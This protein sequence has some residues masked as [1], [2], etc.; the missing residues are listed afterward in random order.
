MFRSVLTKS[1]NWK[2]L[3]KNLELNV[4]ELRVEVGGLGLRRLDSFQIRGGR[5]SGEKE[6]VFSLPHFGR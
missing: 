2:S 1:L 6:R 5:G 4:R 3:T